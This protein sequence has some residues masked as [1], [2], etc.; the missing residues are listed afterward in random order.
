MA[1]VNFG[2][3]VYPYLSF[4][5]RW[6]RVQRRHYIYAKVYGRARDLTV[7]YAQCSTC[8]LTGGKNETV[9]PVLTR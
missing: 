7:N 6:I 2:L 3:D 1:P 4:E 5:A 9:I 8:S